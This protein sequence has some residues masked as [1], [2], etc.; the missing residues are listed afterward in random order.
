[1]A[2][3]QEAVDSP[4]QVV[5]NLP[6]IGA[7]MY[8]SPSYLH[9]DGSMR[10]GSVPRLSKGCIREAKGHHA[11][12]AKK[13]AMQG[14]TWIRWEP[15]QGT[16]HSSFSSFSKGNKISTR[17][18]PKDRGFGYAGSRCVF[19]GCLSFK[20]NLP[21]RWHKATGKRI[22]IHPGMCPQ[23]PSQLPLR[24]CHGK[25][26]HRNKVNPM[27]TSPPRSFP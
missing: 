9:R 18:I 7:C 19:G 27:V 16:S 22:L 20:L 10:L 23:V 6:Q 4:V 2:Q 12:L 3:E 5:L 1:M 26:K 17:S 13:P 15:A 21:S 24:K 14:C 11:P 25:V 8:L